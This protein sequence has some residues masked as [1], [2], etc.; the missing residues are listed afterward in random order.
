[1]NQSQKHTHIHTH[2]VATWNRRQMFI[3]CWFN[4]EKQQMYTQ[5]TDT[6]KKENSWTNERKTMWSAYQ[7]K[8]ICNCDQLGAFVIRYSVMLSLFLCTPKKRFWPR[9]FGAFHFKPSIVYAAAQ[10][11]ELNRMIASFRVSTRALSAITVLRMIC[12]WK[13]LLRLLFILFL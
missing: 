4:D 6:Q 7:V 2:S 5:R 3:Q 9:S 11:I 1:M 12:T 10:N 8:K 13:T